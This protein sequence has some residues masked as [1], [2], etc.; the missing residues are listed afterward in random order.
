MNT[1]TI[2]VFVGGSVFFFDRVEYLWS[3]RS[4]KLETRVEK[5]CFSRI[6]KKILFGREILRIAM[7]IIVFRASPFKEDTK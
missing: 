5:N 1:G 6:G 7:D 4:I 2:R 3:G